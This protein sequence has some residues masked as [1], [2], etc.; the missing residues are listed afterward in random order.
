MTST[1][2][3]PAKQAMPK[4]RPTTHEFHMSPSTS[5]SPKGDDDASPKDNYHPSDIE[6][7][8]EGADGSVKHHPKDEKSSSA[9]INKHDDLD[10]DDDEHDLYSAM[11]YE[12]EKEHLIDDEYSYDDDDDEYSI[13][14][15]IQDEIERQLT[16]EI[17][18]ALQREIDMQLDR[19][20]EEC[21]R[22]LDR[23]LD[24]E[25]S[26]TL[27]KTLQ[28]GDGSVAAGAYHSNDDDGFD[29]D[30]DRQYFSSTH[31][32]ITT[33]KRQAGRATMV[34]GIVSNESSI[35]MPIG[36]GTKDIN[37]PTK[38]KGG[39]D[40]AD[41]QVDVINKL[42]RAKKNEGNSSSKRGINRTEAAATSVEDINRA[43][44]SVIDSHKI[45]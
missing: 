25:I 20:M 24:E 12:D 36:N 16:E 11:V 29:A 13:S 18:A 17:D 37:A 28:I 22:E 38:E 9:A 31:A 23:Q 43:I 42:Q 2:A 40:D 34:Q 7:K 6:N 27:S 26:R 21:E 39:E 3:A 30:V 35:T 41:L 1:Q 14:N 15:Y 45:R 44:Q 32:A 8:C 19:A 4:H 5:S 33:S 10:A